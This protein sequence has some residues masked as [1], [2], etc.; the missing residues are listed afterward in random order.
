M[1]RDRSA[2]DGAGLR[3]AIAIVLLRGD[4]MLMIR[5]AAGVPRPGVW[6]PPTGWIEPGETPA[7]AVER[8][9]R[10]E[11]GLILRAESEVWH[12]H[13]EVDGRPL[14]IGWWLTRHLQGRPNPEP[15]EVAEYRYVDSAGYFALQ[16]TFAQ[17]HPFFACV[18]PG[19]VLRGASHTAGPPA[20]T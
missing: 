19:L 10:E 11:L 16:P 17:H 20:G 3:H 7:E 9:A 14:R 2:A 8:E 12:C 4:R 13:A 5:R 6:S 18:L 15:A 1:G